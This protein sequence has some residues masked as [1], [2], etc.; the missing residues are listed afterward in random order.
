MFVHILIYAVFKYLQQDIS[1]K[2]VAHGQGHFFLSLPFIV[3]TC[4]KP[5]FLCKDRVFSQKIVI[6]HGKSLLFF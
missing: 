6:K 5:F 3:L 4:V 1:N 2:A